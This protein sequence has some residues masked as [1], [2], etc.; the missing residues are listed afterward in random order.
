M[1]Y[2]FIAIGVF[3]FTAAIWEFINSKDKAAYLVKNSIIL[4]LVILVLFLFGPFFILSPVKI[5]YTTVEENGV[6]LIYPENKKSEANKIM[7]LCQEVAFTNDKFFQ[8][9]T[10]PKILLA[11]SDFD[12]LRFGANPKASGASLPWGINVKISKASYGVIAHEMSHLTLKQLTG[13][14]STSFPRWFD[15]GLASYLG[16][17]DYY[18]NL[19]QLKLDV[20]ENRYQD[21]LTS[22]RGLVGLLKWQN[23]IFFDPHRSPSQVYGQSY[24]MIKYLVEKYGQE[25]VDL[26]LV[27]M[28]VLPFHQAF[29]K[30]YGFSEK[31]FSNEFIEYL[32]LGKF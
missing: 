7:K 1:V 31:Q 10:T 21:D 12:M 23:I 2:V 29:E 18:R 17:M 6:T 24:H 22:W 32:K 5:G 15:E 25:K 8:I 19:D 27:T 13:K 20:Y 28:K 11:V 3:V 14:G 26:L 4:F 30:V 16:K 9:K